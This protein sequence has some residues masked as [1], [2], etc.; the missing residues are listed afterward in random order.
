MTETMPMIIKRTSLEY[1]LLARFG[2]MGRDYSDPAG[3]GSE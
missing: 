1:Y 2:L 3:F